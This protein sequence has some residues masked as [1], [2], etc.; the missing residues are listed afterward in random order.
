MM[1][2][3]RRSGKTS[4]FRAAYEADDALVVESTTRRY[5]LRPDAAQG[6]P[7]R[8]AASSA[9]RSNVETVTRSRAAH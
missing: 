3:S 9:F 4:G 8:K 1:C 7:F 5:F 6:S 2:R